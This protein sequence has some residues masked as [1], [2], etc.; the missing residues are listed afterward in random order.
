MKTVYDE[1]CV[2]KDKRKARV[3][4]V[5]A[6]LARHFEIPIW[7]VRLVTVIGFITFPMVVAIAYIAAAFVLPDGY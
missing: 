3:A 4:G 2:R 1:S 6:G 7:L 5:C